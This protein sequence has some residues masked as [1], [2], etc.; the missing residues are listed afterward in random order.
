MKAHLLF[1]LV[2]AASPS[3]AAG[4]RPSKAPPLPT[5]IIETIAGT[6]LAAL[7]ADNV[8]PLLSEMYLPQDVT[9]GP[10]GLLYITDWNNHRVRVIEN[11][12]VRTII[13]TGMLGDASE[14]NALDVS[15]N[16]PTHV[17]FGPDGNLY[18]SAWHNSKIMKYDM[19]TLYLSTYCSWSGAR[20]WYGDGGLAYDAIVNLPSS[21]AW[22]PDGNMYISDQ[23]NHCVRMI[24]F[25]TNII[26]TVVAIRHTPGFEGDDGPA[27]DA[28][29]NGPFGQVANPAS[30]MIFDATGN[31]YLCDTN[32]ERIRKVDTNGIITTIAGGGAGDDG[33]PAIDASFN[34]PADLAIGPI[35]GNLYIADRLNNRIRMVNLQTGIIA[36]A[37][38]TGEGGFSGD[39]GDPA[40]AKIYEPFGICFDPAGNLYIADTKNHR[41][42]RA[43]LAYPATPTENSTWGRMKALYK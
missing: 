22:G 36:T 5:A 1:A 2:L 20:G 9:V 12:L 24:D 37:V 25:D 16:H 43:Q 41:I 21:T 14:G 30:R 17:S 35:D 42:R 6:G 8:D 38:G 27:I 34:Y 40:D 7:G 11:G 23:A 19:T 10:D 33:G 3:I 18:M 39:G 15:I 4:E 32:N 28:L 29:L 13:G 26:S 31:I